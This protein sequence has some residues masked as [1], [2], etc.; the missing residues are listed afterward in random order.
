MNLHSKK[1]FQDCLLNIINPVKPYYSK[2][3]A[4]LI[5][6][7]TGV[8]YGK[9]MGEFEAFARILWGLAP[10]WG[11]M[12]DTE[13]FDKIY[14]DGIING[15]D[16]DHEEYWGEVKE[17]HAIVEL[18]PIALSLILAPHKLWDPLTESQK[19]NFSK[20]LKSAN[21]VGIKGNNWAFFHTLVN[22]GLK[23]VGE[24]YDQ[25]VIDKTLENIDACYLGGGW[26]SDGKGMAQMDYYIPFAFHFYG[27]IYAKVMENDDPVHSK[28]FKD[29]AMIFAKDFIYWFAPD[30]SALNFGRSQTYRF[31]QVCFFSA[32]VFAG[33]EP[34]SLGVMK[35]IIARHL[36]YWLNQPIFDN[37]GILS[38]GY[39]YPNLFMSER[40]NA[41]GSPYWSLKA[42]L[43]LALSDNHEFFKVEAEPLPELNKLHIIKPAKMVVQRMNGYVTCLTA[44]QLAPWLNPER[45]EKYAKFAYSSKYGYCVSRSYFDIEAA[46]SDSML[47]FIKDGY[48]HIRRVCDESEIRDDGSVFSKWSPCEGIKVETTLI[49]TENGH[50]RKHII[51]LDFDT[52]AY[53]S[54][55]ATD[56]G[57][58]SIE[59]GEE[60][61]IDQVP[62]INLVSPRTRMKAVKYELKKGRNEITTTVVYPD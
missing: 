59:G 7:H 56:D 32:C 47:T 52:V 24:E 27:L 6:G 19:Q 34:F 17:G 23:A 26:Y 15:T 11:G 60:V 10:F 43:L 18:T 13:D 22:L 9:E 1:D 54:A 38:I 20:W 36:N 39:C 58:G 40:Y 30:G 31:A 42:F 4:H 49:P 8:H 44:G 62:N 45:G 5:L 2:G 57:K 14:L 51:D 33:I 41:P 61:L 48:C 46:G 29:R 21:N 55:F 53:D 37:G 25:S 16:P 28:I 12:G 3:K 35:G 50:I